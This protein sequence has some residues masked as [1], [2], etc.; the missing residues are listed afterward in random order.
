[1]EL[2]EKEEEY[3][4]ACLVD[5]DAE[6]VQVGYGTIVGKRKTLAFLHNG[7]LRDGVGYYSFLPCR[8]GE[9]NNSE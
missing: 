5:A 1:M 4:A 9:N 7:R 3:L 8:K 2:P 6:F